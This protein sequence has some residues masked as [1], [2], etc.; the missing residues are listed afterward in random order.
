VVDEGQADKIAGMCG[1]RA[2]YVVACTTAS[3]NKAA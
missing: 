2:N 3:V 1:S